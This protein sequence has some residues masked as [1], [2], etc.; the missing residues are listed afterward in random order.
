[1]EL[2][3][4]GNEFVDLFSR[5]GLRQRSMH[6]QVTELRKL[7]KLVGFGRSQIAVPSENTY[8]PCGRLRPCQVS[9]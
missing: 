2:L 3:E 6:K 7:S 8:E 5:N 9:G 1:M 4:Y